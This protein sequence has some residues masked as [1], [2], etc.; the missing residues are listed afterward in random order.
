M[1]ISSIP[2]SPSIKPTR[3]DF[4]K[5]TLIASATTAIFGVATKVSAAEKS[6]AA[7]FFELRAYRFRPGASADL[8]HGYLEKAFIPALNAR[9][10]ANV[11]VFTEVGVDRKALTAAAI[12]DSPVWVLVTHPTFESF[13]SVSA[14]LNKDPKV[15]AAAA[16]YLQAPKAT[17]AYDRMDTY[18]MRAFSGMPTLEIPSFSKD[19]TPTR[20]FELRHYESHSE[21]KAFSKM[22]MFN[23][24]E[25]VVM[26]D[27][28]MSPVFY[29]QGLAGPNL[30]HLAYMTGARDLA[31]HL[32]N[33][34]KFRVDPRWKAMGR[35][36]KYA[37][38][39]SKGT[40]RIVVPTAYSQ[41]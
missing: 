24:E 15:Q 5:T 31:T 34:N 38:N 6:D 28:G 39:V 22:A 25:I 9:G 13:E 36:P 23:D 29:G 3:R 11:G 21:I 1:T 27:L 26:K 4:L 14:D 37:D 8:V 18:L 16:D 2:N 7:V 30:P 35:N 17:P 19:K 10:L 12:P 41:I 33:W 20:V 32:D 40:N